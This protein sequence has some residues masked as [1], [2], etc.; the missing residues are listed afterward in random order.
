MLSC[1]AT[2]ALAYVMIGYASWYGYQFHM[3]PTASGEVFDMFQITAAHKTLPLGTILK[4]TKVETG[5]S[6]V[7]RVND[8][9]PYIPGRHLDLSYGAAHKLGM[10]EEG[11]A[12]VTMEIVRYGKKGKRSRKSN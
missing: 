7:V 11:I 8:R 1:V 2:K 6:I 3:K 9:G 10:I 5:K 4:V 12:K